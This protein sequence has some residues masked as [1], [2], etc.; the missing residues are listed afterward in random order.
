MIDI[1][2]YFTKIT[3]LTPIKEQVE[4]LEVLGDINIKNVC[5]SAGR[6]FSKTMLSA[7][8]ALW[9]AVEYSDYIGRPL[10]ILLVSGQKRMYLHLNNF[11][12]GNPELHKRLLQSGMFK[13]VP[14][15]GFELDNHSVVDTAMATSKGIRSHRADVIF[16]DE[17]C[18]VKDDIYRQAILP[19]STGDIAKIVILSTPSEP[20]GFFTEIVSDPE[21]YSFTLKQY[22]SEVCPW[23]EV[24]N[25]RLKATLSQAEYATE[26]LARVP[27]RDERAF[28]ANKDIARCI[29]DVEPTA[30]LKERSKLECGI[31]FGYGKRNSTALTITEKQF[32]KRKLIFQREWRDVS[33]GEIAACL[34]GFGGTI[35][36]DSRPAEFKGKLE[37]Y[38][39]DTKIYYLDMVFH[40]EHCITQLQTRIRM[41]QLTIPDID[42]F[43]PLVKE[44]RV[45]KLHKQTN[46]NLVDSLAISCYEPKEPLKSQAPSGFVIGQPGRI[47]VS[48]GNHIASKRSAFKFGSDKG[49]A[50]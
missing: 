24:S 15:E 46:D 38:L 29:V 7:L 9:F 28:F 31:D 50:N 11:F 33:F 49:S 6:G 30:E 40:K 14:E 47:I 8:A 1:V 4:V 16:V 48:T 12:R 44:L 10:E 43:R 20:Q 17:A 37:Q 32:T 36:A 21:K 25:R 34:K 5:L 42:G 2:S 35:K 41:H 19:V 27:S 13:E 18:L 22:S 26:V 3:G 39:P 23:Q 45:Y